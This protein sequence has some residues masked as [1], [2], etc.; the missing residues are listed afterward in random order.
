MIFTT[1]LL[2]HD[3]N[4]HPLGSIAHNL[5]AFGQ[6]TGRPIVLDDVRCVGNESQ[7]RNCSYTRTHN[8]VH[9]EDAG[10]TCAGK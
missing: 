5:A 9:L 8:C 1:N 3:T 4:L 2:L 6:G 7:I 10:V